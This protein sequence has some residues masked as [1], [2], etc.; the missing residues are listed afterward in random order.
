MNVITLD[1]LRKLIKE[2]N[3]LYADMRKHAGEEDDQDLWH[4]ATALRGEICAYEELI[5][6]ERG[7]TYREFLMEK[8]RGTL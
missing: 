4:A 3:I 5:K 7:L 1:Y 2:G 6:V 8:K